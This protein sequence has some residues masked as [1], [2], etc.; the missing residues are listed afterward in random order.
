MQRPWWTRVRTRLR[1]FTPLADTPPPRSE[2]AINIF[3]E[4]PGDALRGEEMS[5]GGERERGIDKNIENKSRIARTINEKSLYKGCEMYR[6]VKW[7]MKERKER[8]RN[9][10]ALMKGM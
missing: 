3:V 1:L 7:E 8:K 9:V 4:M 10:V 6:R 5:K 2:N